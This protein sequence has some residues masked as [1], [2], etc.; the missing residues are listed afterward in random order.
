NHTSNKNLS[1]NSVS[2]QLNSNITTYY[3]QKLKIIRSGNGKQPQIKLSDLKK[4]RLT[5]CPETN[6]SLEKIYNKMQKN[7]LDCE[8]AVDAIDKILA[9]FYGISSDELEYIKEEI[10]R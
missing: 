1:L 10:S 3:A 5:D 4:I 7:L 2:C 9:Q 6:N 8:K